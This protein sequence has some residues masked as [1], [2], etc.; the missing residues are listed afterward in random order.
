MT[1]KIA[2][3]TAIIL[4]FSTACSIQDI[5]RRRVN[6]FLC[7]TAIISQLIFNLIFNSNQF[8]MYLITAIIAA[9]LYFAVRQITHKR[10]GPA[11]IFFAA[12]QA[13]CLPPYAFFFCTLLSIV[14]ALISGLT[15]F[16]KQ[17]IPFIPFMATGLVLSYLFLILF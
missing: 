9:A 4:F 15:V 2:I 7:A 1:L 17:K 12:F 10:L 3:Q 13:L 16:K 5:K 11:D 8:F 14:S 6:N